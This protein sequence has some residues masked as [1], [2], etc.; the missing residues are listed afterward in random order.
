MTHRMPTTTSSSAKIQPLLR[1]W[2]QIIFSICFIIF[3]SS[4]I[5]LIICRTFAFQRSGYL[6]TGDA[7]GRYPGGKQVEQQAKQ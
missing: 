3:V 1:R 4:F 7:Q 2:F 6:F 5:G